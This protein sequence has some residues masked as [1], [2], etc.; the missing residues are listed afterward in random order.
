MI[1]LKII[2]KSHLKSKINLKITVDLGLKREIEAQ[3]EDMYFFMDL[4]GT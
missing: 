2:R 1:V 3:F 4:P